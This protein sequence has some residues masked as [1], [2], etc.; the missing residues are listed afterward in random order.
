MGIALNR[1]IEAEAAGS[2]G[3]IPKVVKGRE[4]PTAGVMN[5]IGQ[6]MTVTMTET[7][8]LTFTRHSG[9]K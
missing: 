3:T 8:A 4:S 5:I 7:D 9:T 2:A 6:A 1:T